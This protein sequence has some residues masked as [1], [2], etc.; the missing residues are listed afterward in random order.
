MQVDGLSKIIYVH[1]PRTGGSWFSNA[2]DSQRGEGPVWLQGRILVNK[3]N[4]LQQ[5][6]GKHGQLSGIL[7][8]LKKIDYDYS[9]HKIITLV[10]EPID[11]VL[12]SWI[13]F[14]KVKGTAEK[15]GWKTIDDMLDEYEQGHVRVNYLPQVFWLT[16]KNAHWDKIYRF[17]DLLISS[18]PVQK[19]FPK[20]NKGYKNKNRLTRTGRI[21][22]YKDY[23]SG[24]QVARI[25]ELYKEDIK[26]LK[27]YY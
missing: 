10:R 19:D 3:E 24:K 7:E 20:F 27:D 9:D 14:S 26:F 17:E 22:G 2:W 12:S 18:A 25:S 8:K 1:I 16:E 21:N 15:H 5:E 6:C 23:L 11:R 4:Q 13:W